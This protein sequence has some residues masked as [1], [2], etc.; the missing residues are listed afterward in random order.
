MIWGEGQAEPHVVVPVV[1]PI[2]VPVGRPAVLGVIVPTA[3]AHDAV[4]A[5][6]GQ[7]PKFLNKHFPESQT[8]AIAHK[9]LQGLQMPR[10]I[11]FRP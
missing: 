9:G 7:N 2:V 3:A 6:S 4:G 10:Q 1:R 11:A 5:F 8:V